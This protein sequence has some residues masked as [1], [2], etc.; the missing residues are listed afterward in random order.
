MPIAVVTDEMPLFLR[1]ALPLLAIACSAADIGTRVSASP[2][3]LSTRPSVEPSSSPMVAWEDSVVSRLQAV[4]IYA[5]SV[6]D[7]RFAGVLGP[8]LPAR[9]FRIG[10]RTWGGADILFLETPRDIRVCASP[11]SSP[12]RTI[13]ATFVSGEQTS[14]SDAG[15]YVAHLVSS[16]FFVMAWDEEAAAALQRGLGVMPAR[17]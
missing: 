6:G 9:V 16:Q 10:P 5:Q 1:L 2:P 7:S 15:Q 17:C 8:L 3:T 13:Y 14:T 11:G 4:G 12:G